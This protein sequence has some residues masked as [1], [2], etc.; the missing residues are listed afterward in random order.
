MKTICLSLL[1]SAS[2]LTA[3][4]SVP[5]L[6][7]GVNGE[8]WQEGG[9]LPDFS[10]AGYHQGE[11][12]LPIRPYDVSVSTFGAL[13]DGVHDDS[14]AFQ[15][16]INASKGKVIY[17]PPGKYL[18]TK[19][20]KIVNHQGTVLQGAG[21]DAT[22]LFF[23][24]SLDK[25]YPGTNTPYPG[26]IFGL[27]HSYGGL[28][29]IGARDDKKALF[30]Q[31]PL[32]Q[33]TA[34]AP[35]GSQTLTVANTSALHVGQECILSMNS[36]TTSLAKY[37]LGGDLTHFTINPSAIQANFSF[38]IECIAGNTITLNR[39]LP[40]N[41]DLAWKSTLLP[42][43]MASE[44]C[45]IQDLTISFGRQKYVMPEPGY[46]GVFF[47]Y[48]RNSYLRRLRIKNSDN[49]IIVRGSYNNT[50]DDIIF[51]CNE[52]PSTPTGHFGIFYNIAFDNLAN[53]ILFKSTFQHGLSVYNSH[54]NVSRN[55]AGMNG[56]GLSIDHRG[57]APSRNLFS[58]IIAQKPY[59]KSG[60]NATDGYKAGEY[61]TYWHVSGVSSNWPAIFGPAAK[62]IVGASGVSSLNT[63]WY[64]AIPN[65][66]LTPVELSDAQFQLRH[67]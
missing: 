43:K 1:L 62:N 24:L 28:I 2:Y 38:I 49:A 13:G 26:S 15:K 31:Q 50:F 18:I 56:G 23:P 55:S 11:I 67:E 33:V 64:E 47:Q 21:R 35:Q 39:K 40:F 66:T 57:Q 7:F 8:E 45:G 63:L 3:I 42:A 41:V 32:T 46:N 51:E 29:L 30:P 5:S 34:F 19:Q 17:I 14:D 9:R 36:S 65:N 27:Y 22:T 60:N 4:P 61:E 58:N 48:T 16:A 10:Y 54:L 59:S 53:N 12:P 37:L 6:L 20:L 52:P 44:E 25:I